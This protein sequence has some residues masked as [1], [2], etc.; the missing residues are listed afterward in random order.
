MSTGAE[1][2]GQKVDSW[3]PTAGDWVG[4]GRT[5]VT[6]EYRASLGHDENIWKLMVATVAQ[7]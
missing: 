3:L 2:T 7:L 6:A 1:P 4:R 5:R